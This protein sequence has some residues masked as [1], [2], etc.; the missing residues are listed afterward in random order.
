MSN[1]IRFIGLL[2]FL[3][4]NIIYS[5]YCTSDGRFT[6]AEYFS[7]SEIDST[8]GV[9]YA[10]AMDWQGNAQDLELDIYYP[11]NASEDLSERPFI[12][13]IHGGG[14][15]IGDK[16]AMWNDCAEFAKRGYVAATMSY[17]LG[18]DTSDIF[19]AFNGVYR[20]QQDANAALRYMVNNAA[21]YSI[22]TDWMFIGGE[23]AG[24]VTSLNVV[25]ADQADWNGINPL[26][27]FSLGALNTSGNN[28]TDEFTLKGVYNSWGATLGSAIT[29]SE[30]IPNISFH[31]LLDDVVPIGA[32]PEGLVGSA[33]IHDLLIN[34]NVCSELVVDS[35]GGHGIYGHGTIAG[36]RFRA[37]RAACFFKSVI[38]NS[39][40]SLYLTEPTPANCTTVQVKLNAFLEGSFNAANN[41]MY[42]VLRDDNLL[43]AQQ[44]FNQS[45][46]F[47]TG[48]ESVPTTADLPANMVNWVLVEIRDGA[49]SNTI[50]SQKAAA[51]LSDGQIV[52]VSGNDLGFADIDANQNYFIAIKTL[53]HLAVLS[54]NAISLPNTISYDFSNPNNVYGGNTQLKDM[55]G[56]NHALLAG[57]WNSDGTITVVDFNGYFSESSSI[58]QYLDGDFDLNG[59][60]TVADYNLFRA[61]LSAIGASQ[62]QY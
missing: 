2:L 38:C 13:L 31:G 43:P 48:T 7:D 10:N 6:N 29:P 18:V 55:G 41:S 46:W 12:L 5:Q 35:L 58:S 16:S 17:R 21:N 42:T 57:D 40:T 33:V 50:I 51:I 56:G 32:T 62:I 30:M 1:S 25:Y 15:F 47:Y 27:Q 20:A 49:D 26:L 24:G 45:P 60:V 59:Q 22:D 36:D 54:Q 23:S 61:N 11:S 53:N 9:I 37:E 44:P 28:L 52:D 34:N 3:L 8:M 14:F 39:C 4:P 19:N